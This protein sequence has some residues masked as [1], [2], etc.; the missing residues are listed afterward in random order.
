M[1]DKV[2]PACDAIHSRREIGIGRCAA[3][4]LLTFDGENI[5]EE[6]THC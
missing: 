5:L 4:R 2:C 6:R 1:A 3:V